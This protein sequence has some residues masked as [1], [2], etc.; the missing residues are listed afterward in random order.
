MNRICWYLQG[1]EDNGLVFNPYKRMVVDFYVDAY[2]EEIWGHENPQDTICE[3]IRTVFVL[4]FYNCPLLWV[5]NSQTEMPLSTFNYEYVLL[6]QYI[7]DL[8]PLKCLI[9]EVIDTLGMDDEKLKFVSS[10]I[11]MRKRMVL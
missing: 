4:I 2:V 6:S 8:L 11:F 7:R 10:F 5:S 9:K 3:K 1:I